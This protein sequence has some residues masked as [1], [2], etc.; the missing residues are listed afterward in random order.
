MLLI[1]QTAI[2]EAYFLWNGKRLRSETHIFVLVK[3]L[4]FYHKINFE[5]E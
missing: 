5:I 2:F 1:C 4:S 3:Y